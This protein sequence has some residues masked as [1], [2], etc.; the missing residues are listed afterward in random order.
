MDETIKELLNREPSRWGNL[1]KSVFERDILLL[2]ETVTKLTEEASLLMAKLLFAY[3]NKDEDFPRAFE[4]EAVRSAVS[5]LEKHYKGE[6]F[7]PSSFRKMLA[8]MEEKTE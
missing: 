5:H 8:E 1:P 4:V 2:Q 3:Q 6:M 7:S